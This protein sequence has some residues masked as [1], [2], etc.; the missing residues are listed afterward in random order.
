MYKS[1]CYLKAFENSY[2]GKRELEGGREKEEKDDATYS[3]KSPI[4]NLASSLVRTFS[5]RID[6][7]SS[8]TVLPQSQPFNF[9]VSNLPPA[10]NLYKNKTAGNNF[11]LKNA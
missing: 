4:S 11:N 3:V 1:L 8:P 5:D 9:S 10:C 2:G 6:S 7:Q